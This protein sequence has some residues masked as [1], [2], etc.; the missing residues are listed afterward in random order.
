MRYKKMNEIKIEEIKKNI[1]KK[2]NYNS[3]II[4]I[5]RNIVD[6]MDE[7]SEDELNQCMDDELIYTSDIWTVIQYYITPAELG[8]SSLSDVFMYFYEDILSCLEV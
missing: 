7:V 6:R 3:D 1:I 8:N 5:A 4:D 2:F